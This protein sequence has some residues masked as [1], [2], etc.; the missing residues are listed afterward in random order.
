MYRLKGRRQK[1]PVYETGVTERGE[2][3]CP[4]ERW[5]RRDLRAAKLAGK[6]GEPL[7]GL[8]GLSLPWHTDSLNVRVRRGNVDSA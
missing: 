6:V 1:P 3:S 8:I 4:E 2:T 7:K 5:R